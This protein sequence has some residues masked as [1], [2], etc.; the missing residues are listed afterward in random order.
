MSPVLIQIRHS[1]GLGFGFASIAVAVVALLG[2]LYALAFALLGIFAGRD[3][4]G[5]E[6]NSAAGPKRLPTT[7]FLVVIPA[8]NEGPGL[9]ATVQSV[10]AQNYPY[11]RCVVIADNCT[12]DT[13]EMAKAAGAHEVL[14]RTDPARRGKGQ[15]LT[16]AFNL[17][18]RW[19]WDAVCVIDADSVIEPGF[20][21]AFDHS[22]RKGHAVAQARYDFFPAADSKDW[23]QQ[24]GAV[25]KAGENSFVFRPRERLGLSEVLVGNGFFLSRA[26]LERVPWVAHSIV[27]DAEYSLLLGRQGIAVHFQEDARLWSRQASSVRDVQPQRVRWASGIWQLFRKAIPIL[28]STAWHER[29]WRAI[30]EIVMLLM[31]S[32]LVLIYLWVLSFAMSLAAPSLFP[33]T[34]S[35]L[36]GVAALQALYLMLMF[37]FACDHPVPL[38]GALLLPYYVFVL[39]SSQVVAL[40]GTNRDLWWRTS[41]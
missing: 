12:D 31:S 24:F 18:Q 2:T 9:T 37:R 39:L 5:D 1:V 23:L 38:V 13:S 16:W 22:F 30:E 4:D 36:A 17:A 28:F 6:D 20:F 14:V 3:D 26:V 7:N 32:R 8:H 15:A 41:R 21:A 29:S 40:T 35:L 19:E 27:E 10:L 11:L 33:I 34:W 25:S